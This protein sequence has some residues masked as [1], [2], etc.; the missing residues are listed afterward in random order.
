MQVKLIVS[1]ACALSGIVCTHAGTYTH[2]RY[3]EQFT[4][5]YP[6]RK[7]TWKNLPVKL[8]QAEISRKHV[9]GQ[10]SHYPYA[11]RHPAIRLQP[12]FTYAFT[13]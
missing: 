4:S 12:A 9:S 7:T 6:T 13:G 8:L 1:L 11:A 5:V 10:D 2:D 3:C